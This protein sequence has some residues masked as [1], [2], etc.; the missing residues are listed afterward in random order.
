MPSPNNAWFIKGTA[1]LNT[2]VFR[3]T[4]GAIGSRFGKAQVL[5]LTTTGRKSGKQRTTPLSYVDDGDNVAVVASNG[6]RDDA[7]LWW[8][9]LQANPEATIRTRRTTRNVRAQQ[10]TAEEQSRLWP[11]AD[12]GVPG[13]R[14][15]HHPH[16]AAD[17]D[18]DPAEGVGRSPEPAMRSLAYADVVRMLHM[19]MHR[20]TRSS[21]HSRRKMSLTRWRTNNWIGQSGTVR[22]TMRRRRWRGGSR[23]CRSGFGVRSMR[24]RGRCG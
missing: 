24:G 15:L 14:R 2:M 10:A 5:L 23:S 8:R 3:L 17:P 20:R 18:R 9:N 13:L 12:G 22:T 16:D 4:G 21:N 1:R 7:P 11:S 6:G 19:L